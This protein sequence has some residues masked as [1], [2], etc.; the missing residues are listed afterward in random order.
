MLLALLGAGS[1]A[2]VEAD[3]AVDAAAAFGA[4]PSVSGL[5]LSPDGRSVS[6]LTP[7]RGQGA[8]LNVLSLTDGAKPRI[9]LSAGGDPERL[10]WCRWVSNDRLVCEIYAIISD[11][12]GLLGYTRLVAVNA[13]GSNLRLLSKRTSEHAHGVAFGGGA[14]VDWLPGEDGAVLMARVYVP[15]DR[16]DSRIGSKDA[17]YGVDRVDTRDLSSRRIEKPSLDAVEYIADGRGTVRIMGTR[18]RTGGLH[19]SVTT[20]LYRTPGSQEWH[21][22]GDY[23]YLE[24]SGFDP[25]AVDPDLNVA[26]GFK[27]KD[28]RFAL[29]TVLL[30][31]TLTEQLVY[32]NPDVD[33]DGLIRIGRNWRVVG[34]SYATDKRHSVYFAP[35]VE[36]IVAALERALHQE[37][38]L[39]VVDSS[40]DENKLLVFAGQDTDP[41][42]YYI[43]DR[44]ARRLQTFL[45]AR[46]QLEGVK[47]ASQKSI[48][49]PAADGTMIPAY[50]TLPPGVDNPKGLPAIVM[51]H[52]GPE[53]RDYWG[54]NWLT[55]F[56]AARGYAVLQPEFRSS[57]GYGDVWFEQNGFHSWRIAIGDVVAAG[58]WL[59]SEGI[60]DPAKLGIVGWSYGGYAALQS[61]VVEP[62]LFKAVVA[63]APVTDLPLL[64]E[65][66]RRYTNYEQ[67]ARRIGD[68]ADIRDGSPLEQ[69]D[70][71]KAPVILFHGAMDRNVNI[72][73]SQR[74]AARLK[75]LG[76]RCDLVTWDN[77]DHQLEDSSVRAEM[78]RKSDAFLRQAFGIN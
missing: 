49:Y 8:A 64:K 12:T 67:V 68:G 78:L 33:V 42:V 36:Q 27:K 24:R 70:K 69:A 51:P 35:E 25:Y 76:V 4:R 37:H 29:F 72:E 71:I 5:Q 52:G 61:A 40:A 26:Y 74:M 10:E 19:D 57:T 56:Y 43:F 39:R 55:Q 66:S 59:V 17:G 44:K 30:D 20:Y 14:V 9:A 28:G 58:H 7:T 21:K 3:Q 50:L 13:D 22:L 18:S 47:L 34:T 48:T 65:E 73:H 60:A 2:L 38:G 54:F 11:P 63:T 6:Y 15:E 23:D 75:E 31:G 1:A 32:A 53:A 16:S 46:G 77:L 45:V 62:T 41:G